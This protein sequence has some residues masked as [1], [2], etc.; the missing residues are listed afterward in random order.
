MFVDPII[1]FDYEKR[2]GATFKIC[3]RRYHCAWFLI[4]LFLLALSKIPIP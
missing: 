2:E 1:G 4:P 3:S